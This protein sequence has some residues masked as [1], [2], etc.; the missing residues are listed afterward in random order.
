MH[1]YFYSVDMF[2]LFE[3]RK[4]LREKCQRH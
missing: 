4:H 3:I 2:C 1:V